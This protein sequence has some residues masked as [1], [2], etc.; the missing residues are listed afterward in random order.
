MRRKPA[1]MPTSSDCLRKNRMNKTG[2]K[3]LK[4]EL[5]EKIRKIGNYSEERKN[6]LTFKT[7]K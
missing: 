7:N 2:R 6:Q 5:F 1:R 3:I 4:R